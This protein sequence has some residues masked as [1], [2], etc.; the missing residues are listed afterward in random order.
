MPPW[1]LEAYKQAVAQGQA[2]P[3]Q[4]A[5]YSLGFKAPLNPYMDQA[6]QNAAGFRAPQYTTVTNNLIDQAA[7]AG[8]QVRS[9]YDVNINQNYNPTAY[10]TGQFTGQNV[11]YDDVLKG[12]QPNMQAAQ[13][14]GMPAGGFQSRD[15]NFT[16]DQVS[17]Q[18]LGPAERVAAE[19]LGPG[20]RVNAERIGASLVGPGERVGA[21]RVGEQWVNAA[22]M[23][24]AE[25]VN[26]ERINN[27][28]ANIQS[29]QMGRGDQVT[30]PGM[31]PH[32]QMQGPQN[33]TADQVGVGKW[34]D[35]GVRDQYMDP[36]MAAVVQQQQKNAQEI[37]NEQK[38]QVG[39]QAAAAGAFGGT[40]QAV[41]DS[42]MRRDLA[43]QQGGIA[44]TGLQSAYT[45]AQQQYERDRGAGMQAGLANQQANLNAGLANQQMGFNV[46]QANLNANIN[47]GQFGAS[48][49]MQAQLA[50]QQS[51]N[52]M[53]MANQ[54]AALQAQGLGVQTD[55][56]TQQ[57]NQAAGIQ[58]GQM[59]QQAGYNTG[60][61]NAQWQQQAALANQQMAMQ[62]AMANQQYGLQAGLAN[63]SMGME[64]ARLNQQAMMQAAMQ[65]QQYGYQSQAANQ[66]N[67][68]QRQLAN[69]STGLQGQMANQSATLET[70]KANQEAALRASLAN[71]E[72]NLMAQIEGGKMGQSDRQFGAGLTSQENLAQAQLSQQANE[73]NTRLGFEGLQ[74]RYQGGLQAG[75]A[76]QQNYMD[77]QK[78]LEQSRQFGGSLGQQQAEFG[79]DLNYR[80]QMGQQQV[81]SDI[82]RNNLAATGQSADIWNSVGN[83]EGRGFDQSLAA[84][85]QLGNLGLAHQG[86]EQDAANMQ[87]AHWMNQ[88]NYPMQY[89]QNMAGLT[90]QGMNHLG[91]TTTNQYSPKPSIWSTIGN[92]AMTG[93]GLGMNI[94]AP[95]SGSMMGL[96]GGGGRGGGGGMQ[97]WMQ[98]NV[99]PWS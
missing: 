24:P 46:G 6:M 89:A 78:M 45:N 83:F 9:P 73:L 63:Q 90:A 10:Q 51:N 15:Y 70:G 62:G 7:V 79:A 56:A 96:F 61:Q 44:A 57:A 59:N 88:Q 65:N 34:T 71:Q 22:Q 4:L 11:Q 67:E 13:I 12:Y 95:G 74:T 68:T 99:G 16:A 39:G 8:S 29:Y 80:T 49:G 37:F 50:N 52:Q 20:E 43:N 84:N 87:Y 14:G 31:G 1:L 35:A 27:P 66:Q 33:V 28:A 81:M 5:D 92:L 55:L 91:T 23:G 3:N 41:L 72:S 64:Q 98:Q 97:P 69:Q 26:W 38:A 53:A 93:A 60:L 25:R 17:S 77:V 75:M 36:Y 86:M 21:E 47:Q 48:Q 40:R 82:V 85:A 42:A 30:A 94:M 32:Y 76:N 58:T 18:Q 2:A 19:R 54:Q